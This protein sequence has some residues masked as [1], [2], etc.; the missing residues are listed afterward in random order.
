MDTL[1]PFAFACFAVIIATHV[2]RSYN[3]PVREPLFSW[4]PRNTNSRY[5]TQLREIPTVGG[6]SLPGLSYISAVRNMGDIRAVLL[7]GYKKVRVSALR[8]CRVCSRLILLGYPPRI[9]SG[10]G[11]QDIY[12][13]PMACCR[14]GAGNGGGYQET[15]GGRTGSSTWSTG[16][17]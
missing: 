6:S 17:A 15:S 4:V 1:Q 12:A 5:G 13:R 16:G 14:F 9:V 3:N 10:L 8:A 7:E 11:V 2:V